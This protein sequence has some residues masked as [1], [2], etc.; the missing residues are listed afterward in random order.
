MSVRRS[1]TT[2]DDF[3]EIVDHVRELQKDDGLRVRTVRNVIWSC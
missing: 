2:T 3:G 1:S